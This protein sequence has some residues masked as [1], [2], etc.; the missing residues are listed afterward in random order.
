MAL[1]CSL[2]GLLFGVTVS[3]SPNGRPNVIIILSDDLGYDDLYFQSQEILTPN[4]DKFRSE[5]QFMEWHYAQAVCSPSRAA[6]MTG[7]YPLHTGI[8]DY[9]Q[10]AQAFG[11]PLNNTMLPEILHENGYDTHMV[12]KWHLGYFQW[13][14]TPTFRGFNSFYGYY[15]GGED[16]FTHK[17]NGYYDFRHDVGRNCGANCSNVCVEANEKYS[18]QLF[19]QRAVEVITE[20]SVTADTRDSPLFL[21]LAYQSVHSP[22]EVPSYWKEPYT[23]I[24]NTKRRTFAGMLSCMD[25]GIGNVSAA[26]QKYGYLD[27]NTII[28]FSADNGGP[29]TT[30]DAVGS[31]NYPLRGGKHSIWE[32]G[33]RVTAFVWAT[34][35]LIPRLNNAVIGGN[36]TQLTHLVDWLPT[37]LEA[38]DIEYAFPD[39][40]EIDGVS[41]WKGLRYGNHFDDKFFEFRD[42]VYY[43]IDDNDQPRNVAFR[44]EWYKIFNRSGGNPSTW[45]P[46][47]DGDGD[48]QARETSAELWENCPVSAPFE[49]RPLASINVDDIPMYDLFDDY[50]ERY[51]IS[52]S[53]E[54]KVRELLFEMLQLQATGI[55]QATNDPDCPPITHTNYTEVGPIWEPWC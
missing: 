28:I 17:N 55:P 52:E 6:L 39:G 11:V 9:L 49:S 12:G 20:H 35:D 13:D 21:Y 29:T 37:I 31:S 24:N 25:S 30:G 19:S 23:H 36:Y 47:D 1:P 26:L 50:A 8:N 16:Y 15:G 48:G 22:A 33:T 42:S 43:G 18:T 3:A 46:K 41:Q 2:L 34:P 14:Y 45:S 5:G 7:R 40:L 38:A 4:I 51:D 54:A 10:P 53:N 32:G 44:R 27:E